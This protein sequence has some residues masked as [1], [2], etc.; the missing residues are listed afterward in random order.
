MG[1]SFAVKYFEFKS[2]FGND[3]TNDEPEKIETVDTVK[4]EEITSKDISLPEGYSVEI[5]DI[6][7]KSE[8]C[9]KITIK[10]ANVG[11][12]TVTANK[13]VNE[14]LLVVTDEKEKTLK[15]SG[16][17]NR[18]YKFSELEILIPSSV[19]GL[20]L[21][22]VC[23][24]DADVGKM[25]SFDLC[26]NGLINGK[27]NCDVNKLSLELSGQGNICVS[28]SAK[29]CKI[30]ADGMLCIDANALK[31]DDIELNLQGMNDCSVQPTESL[32]GYTDS[33]S[34][35]RYP[36]EVKKVDVKSPFDDFSFGLGNFPFGGFFNTD[37]FNPTKMFQSFAEGMKA[38]PAAVNDDDDTEHKSRSKL[39]GWSDN[40]HQWMTNA[41][42]GS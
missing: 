37:L 4:S 11:K 41:F 42:W 7:F 2:F 23:V 15:I 17:E 8:N 38:L 10:D 12:V 6:P 28:G 33:S 22:G 35:L 13:N 1:N 40:L 34:I 36:A 26:C 24:L 3:T 30:V 14:H 9:P 32:T 31:T 27:L 29:D 19:P 5:G 16:D 18:C 25:D 20:K 21:N 39:T